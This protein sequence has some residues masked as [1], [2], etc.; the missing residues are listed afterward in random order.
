MNA[1]S[2]IKIL[3][4]TQ[5]LLGPAGVQYLADLGADVIKVEPPWGAWERTW[6]GGDH[7]LNGISPFFLLAH[8]NVRSIT[9]DLKRPEAQEVAGRLAGDADVLVQNFRPGV[10]DRFGLDYE[11]LRH[12]NPGLVYASVSGYGEESPERALPGQDLLIQAMAGLMASTGWMDDPP[13]PAGAAVVDQHGAALLAMGVLAA[14]LHRERTGEG[15]KIEVTMVQAA[16][17]LQLEPATYY[18]NGAPLARPRHTIADTFHAAPYGVYHTADGYLA[19]SMTPVSAL[20]EALGGVPA[21]A[22]FEAPALATSK[23]EEI[24]EILIPILQSRTTGE[25]IAALRERGIWCAPVNDY[26]QVFAEPAVRYLDPV[27]EI[28]HPEA[29]RV[30]LLKHPVRYGAGEPV[31]NHLPP[32]IGEHTEEVLQEAGYS[33]AD[34]EHLRAVGAV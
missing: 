26:D 11:T 30:R 25:W 28:D 24:A 13:T 18:L 33:P 16:L 10:I 32:G 29:G 20:S 12:I 21:L 31:V 15:Q 22:P 14:L 8:R 4:L 27:L 34:I 6:S 3:S 2:G 19:L 9:L 5:F 1:L 17:D 23:R 7:F